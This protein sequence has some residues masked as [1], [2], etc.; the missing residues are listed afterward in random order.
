MT[1]DWPDLG[2]LE[3]LVAVSEHSSISAAARSIDMAQPN[4]S[5]ALRQ[6]ERTFGVQLID[7]HPGGSRLTADGAAVVDWSREVLES[8]QRMRAGTDA[9]RAQHHSQLTVA[10]SMTVAE[11]LMPAWLAELRRAHPDLA[12]KLRVHNSEEVFDS[13]R[14]GVCEMG[15]V[16]SPGVRAGLRHTA[17][18]HDRLVVVVAPE[19][20]WARRHRPVSG[21]ELARTP[22]VVREP[23]SGT[24]TTLE[25]ALGPYGPVVA[26]L[27]L[28][29]NAAVQVSVSAGAGPAVLSELTVASLL[30]TGELIA[31]PTEG[32]N[33]ERS[34]RAVWTGASPVR[35]AA[36][37]LVSIARR[38]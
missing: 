36:A 18:A 30:R 35:T 31:V 21:A 2:M 26:T 19:H 38:L 4:A 11:C 10:A 5:R 24:R 1:P 17:V 12:I 29:S 28:N 34:I 23:G 8:A 14:D 16:E 6:L 15:F 9:L 7:R 37:D 13:V 33:L 25:A 3:L 20:P 32:L 22:L 27:E